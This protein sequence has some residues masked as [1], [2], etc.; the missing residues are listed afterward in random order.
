MNGRF[1]LVGTWGQRLRELREAGLG[2]TVVQVHRRCGAGTVRELCH[3]KAKRLSFHTPPRRVLEGGLPPRKECDFGRSGSVWLRTISGEDS[4][5]SCPLSA[6]PAA[7][8]VSVSVLKGSTPEARTTPTFPVFKI[9]THSL[10]NPSH[11]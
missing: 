3:P 11:S 10:F 9:D 8:E 6:F 4:T 2:S 5:E 1:L 7:E